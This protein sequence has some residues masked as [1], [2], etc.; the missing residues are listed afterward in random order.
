MS[1]SL[2]LQRTV[3]VELLDAGEGPEELHL[4]VALGP[5]DAEDLALVY[6][7]VDR[8]E[9]IALE[10]GDVEADLARPAIGVAVG[11]RL[12]SGR[13]IIS[14]TSASSDIPAA[15]NVPW[16]TP[17]RSTVIRSAIPSTSGSRWLTYMTPTPVLLRSNT[18]A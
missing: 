16:L 11:E 14:A 9:P 18:S 5:G 12:P 2:P 15:S 7:E 3:P 10:P 4:A 13:P 6:L 1:S 17:S 8:P